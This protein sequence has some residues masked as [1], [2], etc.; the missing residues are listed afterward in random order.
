MASIK[1]WI[2]DKLESAFPDL[3]FCFLVTYLWGFIA[4]GYL[5][6]SNSISHDSIDEFLSMTDIALK[7]IG[8]GRFFVPVVHFLRGNISAPWWLGFL[9]LL[10]VS[11]A[12]FFLIRT[13]DIREKLLIFLTSG[14]LTV[15]TSYIALA[16]TYI[17]D[18]DCNSLALLFSV[19]AVYLWRRTKY[20]AVYGTVPIALSLGIYQSF[21]SVTITLVVML[22]IL[23]L[24]RGKGFREVFLPGLKAIAM[25][26]GGGILY[27]CLLKV[28]TTFAAASLSAGKYNSLDNILSL[29]PKSLIQLVVSTWKFTVRQIITVNATLPGR[30]ATMTQACVLLVCF[31]SVLPKLFDKSMAVSEKIL[32]I[33]LSGFLPVGM[34]VSRIL[35]GGMSHDL[36][37]FAMWLVYLLALLLPR[38]LL[39]QEGGLMQCAKELCQ[40]TAIC[41]VAVILY[42]NVQ[43]A[44]STYT[45]K[46]FIQD[47][48]LSMF[49]RIVSDIEEQEDYIPGETLISFVGSPDL[50]LK[51]MPKQYRR[52]Y[53]TGFYDSYVIGGMVHDHYQCYFDYVLMNPGKI[54]SN[55]QTQ[56]LSVHPQVSAM[57]LYPMHGSIAMVD[58]VLVVKL[59]DPSET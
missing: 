6:L 23:D 4:H 57:P 32:L 2:S 48:N 28:V 54:A 14:I 40:L 25:V 39:Q 30:L 56:A 21:L 59:G 15:N 50:A 22:S 49:T 51:D 33:L 31:V 44:N 34:N 19:L 24:V 38:E 7:K 18:L 37:Y 16:A 53:T 13:F 5:F 10:F 45:A 55:D 46:R 11:L 9:S 29:T 58:G 8:S 36:M 12:L 41:L 47:A 1:K 26:I 17:H 42:G 20:G 52:F 3:K 27:F 43:I 35:S